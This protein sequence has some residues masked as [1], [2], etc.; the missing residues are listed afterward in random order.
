MIDLHTHSTYSDGTCSPE[1]LVKIAKNTGIT[2]LALTDHDTIAGVFETAKL[3]E[4][5]GIR[6][7]PGVEVEVESPKGEFHLLGLGLRKDLDG[8]ERTLSSIRNYRT[9]RNIEIV[10]KMNDAGLDI[11][12]GDAEEL[13]CGEIVARPHFAKLLVKRKVVKS[14]EEAFSRFL[15]KGKD[16]YSPKKTP[17]LETAIGL[18]KAAGGVPV[19]AHPFSLLLP[20]AD[21]KDFLLAAKEKGLE[22]IE[23][24]HPQMDNTTSRKLQIFGRDNGFVITGGSDFHGDNSPGIK[25]GHI[26]K[27]NLIPS[28]LADRFFEKDR[29][30]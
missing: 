7:V 10:K 9:E 3:A 27:Y 2:T 20:W 11:T 29:D 25:M 14:V 13:A 1:K 23:A 21:L 8:F 26:S 22:G 6:F 4:E 18:I 15:E 16:F 5:A 30:S 17:T 28:E 12:L 24:Y 19:I